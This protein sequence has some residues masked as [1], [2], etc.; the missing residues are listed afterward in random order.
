MDSSERLSLPLASTTPVN[1]TIPDEN[2]P[3]PPTPPVRFEFAP[4]PDAAAELLKTLDENIVSKRLL[5]ARDVYDSLIRMLEE[6]NSEGLTVTDEDRAG[7]QQQM[8]D[9]SSEIEKMLVRSDKT[10]QVT[11]F[12]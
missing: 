6:E 7:I 9:R 3:H 8:K 1:M 4:I 2:N 5:A 12:D 10:K 11:E